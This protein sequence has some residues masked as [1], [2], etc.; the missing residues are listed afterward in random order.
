M[1]LCPAC[2]QMVAEE[3]LTC[4]ACGREVGGGRK[5]IDGYAILEVLHEGYASILCRAVPEGG[6]PATESVMVR[7]FTPESGVNEEIAARLK[8]ELAELKALPQDYFVQHYD[9]RQS[10]DGSWYRVSEWINGERWGSLL[11]SGR[12]QDPRE[13]FKLFY[14][15]ASIL[16]GLHR[17]GHFIPHLILDDIIVYRDGDDD[18]KV[19]IDYKLS[20]FLDP[21]ISRPGPMLKRLLECHPDMANQRPL[22]LRSDIWSLGKIFVELLTADL[23]LC[24]LTAPIDQLPIPK[25]ARVLLKVMLA[26][27]P[28]MRPGSMDEVA[29]TL[30]RILDQSHGWAQPWAAATDSGFSPIRAIRQLNRRVHLLALAL[31]LVLGVVIWLGWPYLDRQGPHKGEDP[32]EYYANRYAHSVAI[33]V[34]EYWIK[35]D[36]TTVYLNRSEGTAFLVDSAGYLLTNRHVACPWLEDARL[37]AIIAHLQEIEKAGRF[38]YRT[39]L[40]FEGTKA[41]RRLP[42]LEASRAVEDNYALDTAYSKTG[43]AKVTIA[44]VARAPVKT[45][46]QIKYPLK[47]D[48]AVLHIDPVPEGLHPLPLETDL[49]TRRIPKLAPVIALGFPLGS[50]TQETTVNVSVTRGSVRRAFEQ[51]LQ[52]DTSIYRGNSG[53][54]IIDRRGKVIGI[55]SSVYMEMA[56][57]PIPVATA[58]SDIGMVLPINP[59]VP[60][61]AAL[62]AGERKWNGVLDLGVDTKVES[63]VNLA[64]DDDWA[65][66]RDQVTREVSANAHPALVV[67]AGMINFGQ[68]DYDQAAVWFRQALSMGVDTAR[69]QWMLYL[70][71]ELQNRGDGSPHRDALINLDWR[72]PD[73][74]YGHLVRVLEGDVGPEQALSGGY[75]PEEESWLHW[76]V[77]MTHLV[78]EDWPGAEELYTIA[79]QKLNR[80]SWLFPLTLSRLREARKA[81][82][83]SI[84]DETERSA[85]K[86]EAEAQDEALVQGW[87]TA[88]EKWGE[89]LVLQAK[90]RQPKTTLEE[91]IEIL[92]QMDAEALLH[93]DDLVGLVYHHAMSG[94]WEQALTHG[95]KFLD[96][97]GRETA[98]RLSVGLL[99]PEILHKQGRTDEARAQLEQFHQQVQDPWYR[100]L[101]GVILGEEEPAT[102]LTLDGENPVFVV[103]AH[104]ALGFWAEGDEDKTRALGHY[105]EALAS[106][107]DDRLEYEFALERF[108]YLREEDP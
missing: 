14:R 54:P 17:I 61:L 95:Q 25:N 53:G 36:D 20:R 5:F 40:W 29:G 108:K 65:E 2:D 91:K 51:M 89:R 7:I 88:R 42:E 16:D 99:M 94:G 56:T 81:R 41:F 74:F 102:P 34:V 96:L 87:H 43:P 1:K 35:V 84:I 37:A 9:I 80:P 83:S 57:A 71:D 62:K 64:V 92:E 10:S 98:G 58:L 67:A 22:D 104:S 45:W 78:R 70:M 38:G 86:T 52:V 60:F 69:S 31:V 15:V 18:L 19:K 63:L 28:D 6:D 24:D 26:T 39:F 30:K 23:A 49:D 33:V 32:L 48:F 79:A 13:A 76:T 12:L 44:G 11:A 27:E 93:R 66:A 3:I 85:L 77:G 8:R 50:R 97:S 82:L 105:R 46:E 21:A 72:S 47:N 106:Y 90:L 100:S 55:A 59:A 75:S 107:M 68:K 101:S 103:T 4:P 73:E